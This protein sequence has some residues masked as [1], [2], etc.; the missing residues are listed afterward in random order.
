MM[1]KTKIALAVLMTTLAVT[2]QRQQAPQG[3]ETSSRQ[4]PQELSKS[5]HSSKG[6]EKAAPK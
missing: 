5:S 1:I 2:S 4:A 3:Y 6:G